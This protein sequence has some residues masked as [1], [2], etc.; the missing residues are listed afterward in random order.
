MGEQTKGPQ[1]FGGLFLL[2]SI[3]G[4]SMTKPKKFHIDKRASA[5][6]AAPGNDDELLSTQQ[7]AAW[8]GVSHQWL[9]IR[10]HR[11][12]GPPFER[13]GPRCVRYRRD[14]VKAW[15]DERSHRSTEEYA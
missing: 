14:K 2:A 11:N 15:L 3:E 4:G 7:M 12:D 10:R 5:V 1:H 6:A 13:L 8:F 9:E